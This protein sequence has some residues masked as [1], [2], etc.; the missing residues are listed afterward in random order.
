MTSEFRRDVEQFVVWLKQGRREGERGK[1]RPLTQTSRL[2]WR[3]AVF[4]GDVVMLCLMTPDVE[5]SSFS[6][7]TQH[8]IVFCTAHTLVEA[9]PVV[10]HRL[11][12]NLEN[13]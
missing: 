10:H 8:L 7:Q 3:I 9:V 6:L 4:H 13:S 1:S 2:D 11:V 5:S 12:Q